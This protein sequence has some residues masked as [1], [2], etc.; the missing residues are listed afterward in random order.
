MVWSKVVEYAENSRQNTWMYISENDMSE[1]VMPRLSRPALT[2]W[3]GGIL[4]IG[5][6]GIGACDK[7]GL[8]RFYYS[9]D[10]G[11]YWRKSDISLPSGFSGTTC[12][13]ATTS[14]QNIWIV[15]GGSGQVWYGRQP[16]EESN[17]QKVFT[18]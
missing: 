10:G 5:G 6:P 8:S 18:D 12:S 7:D 11:I 2:C 1:Y 17:D 13:V 4:A 9:M 16:G 15:C 14:R 3:K